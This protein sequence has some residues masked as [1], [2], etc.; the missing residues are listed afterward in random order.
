V[1]HI[2]Q[3]NAYLYTPPGSILSL[4][5]HEWGS[6]RGIFIVG[7]WLAAQHWCKRLFQW[8]DGLFM[9]EMIDGT[10]LAQRALVGNLC[11]NWCQERRG[12]ANVR[13]IYKT[14]CE[15]SLVTGEHGW[16]Q[17]L[18]MIKDVHMLT[19]ECAAP[20]ALKCRVR[21]TAVTDDLLRALE[22]GDTEKCLHLQPG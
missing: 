1:L 13:R 5:L 3:Y 17:G 2:F 9:H 16:I 6:V 22:V 10:C 4:R 18:T 12:I 15:C 20:G 14:V 19:A 8:T 11:V 21:P 7:G